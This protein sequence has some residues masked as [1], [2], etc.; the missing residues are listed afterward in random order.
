MRHIATFPFDHA[1]C[2]VIGQIPNARNTTFPL[3]P[4][5]SSLWRCTYK[6]A[7]ILLSAD[8]ADVRPTLYLGPGLVADTRKWALAK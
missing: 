7:R 2:I 3:R 6:G 5:D 8:I 4:F 1:S